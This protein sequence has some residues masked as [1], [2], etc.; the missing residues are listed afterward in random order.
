MSFLVFLTA[1]ESMSR[2][3]ACTPQA[4]DVV[5]VIGKASGRA[6]AGRPSKSVQ[7]TQFVI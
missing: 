4:A 3:H 2:K 6:K 1:P 5:Q 7:M